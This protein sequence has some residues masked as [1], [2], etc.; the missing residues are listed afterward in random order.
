V[1]NVLERFG[2]ILKGLG[3]ILKWVGEVLG[4]FGEKL[5]RNYGIRIRTLVIIIHEIYWLLQ[6][7][8]NVQVP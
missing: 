3:D 1:N 8:P 4:I 6:G 7:T 5:A 2:S